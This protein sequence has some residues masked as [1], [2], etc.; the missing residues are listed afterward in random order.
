MYNRVLIKLSGEGL[1]L[2]SVND[3]ISNHT[4]AQLICQIKYIVQAGVQVAIVVGGGNI[5]RGN[6]AQKYGLDLITADNVGMLATIIN[7]TILRS[8]FNQAGL[9]TKLYSALSVGSVVSTYNQYDVLDDLSNGYVSILV[10]GTGNP[11]FTTDTAAALRAVELSVDLLIKLTK[12]DGAFDK[13]P[14]Q[15]KSAK[16]YDNVSFSFVL[17]KGLSVMDVAA[18]SICQKHNVPIHITNMF[19]ENS[20]SNSIKGEFSGTLIR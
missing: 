19:S 4:V 17:E 15:Y 1:N 8:L 2:H 6:C 20:L 10:G 12:I 11:L 14:M 16:K 7:G 18:F 3:L 13:D 5:F 9:K